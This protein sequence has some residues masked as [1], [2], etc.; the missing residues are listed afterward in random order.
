MFRYSA[1]GVAPSLFVYDTL[2]RV[3]RTGLDATGNG[4][5]DLASAARA[6]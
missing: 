1:T 5:L 6:L 4:T 2:G 3:I